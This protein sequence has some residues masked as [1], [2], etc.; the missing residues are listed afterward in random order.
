MR[1]LKHLFGNKGARKDISIKDSLGEF[2]LDRRYDWFEG[3]I[4]WMGNMEDV[5]LKKDEDADTAEA[6]LR[7][8]HMLMSDVAEWDSKLRKYAAE[9]LTELAND[10]RENVE[11]GDI[12]KEEFME[13]IGCPS[14]SIDNKGDFEVVY[15][16][17]D[18]FAGHWIVV[19]GTA[20]GELTDSDIEG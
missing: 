18:M 3:Q 17:D 13:R 1:G 9:E 7:T 16:D 8:L 12:R 10:W 14:F 15:N 4:N 19:Y 5:S 20:D 11:D 2:K 6:A